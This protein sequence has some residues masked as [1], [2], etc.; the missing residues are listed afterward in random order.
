[1]DYG[2]YFISTILIP[3]SGFSKKNLLLPGQ[4]I[5]VDPPRVMQLYIPPIHKDVNAKQAAINYVY[6]LPSHLCDS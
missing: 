3:H 4:K 2:G 1:M 5:Q 6:L